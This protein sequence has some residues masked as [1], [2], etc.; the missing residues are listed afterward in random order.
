MGREIVVRV[1][2][3]VRLRAVD[4]WQVPASP[5]LRLVLGLM[6]L[7]IGQVVP[8]AELIDAIWEDEP[9]RSARASL[10]ALMTRLRQL[11]KPLPGASFTRCGDGYLF[12]FDQ[13]LV[14]AERSRSLGRAARAADGAGAIPLFDAALALWNG[15][16]LA[17]APD[18]ERVTAIRH[19]LAEERLS[20][21]QDRLAC[22]LA[23]GGEREAAAELPVALARHP[24]NERLAGMLMATWYRSGQRAEALAVFRQIRARLDV[25][26]N[27]KTP[28]YRRGRIL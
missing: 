26:W 8:V 7:R 6:A 21:L 20:M 28:L 22:M 23:C 15:P 13:D 4:R 2:G 24:L 3:P 9:P 11:L 27:G 18:T 1:L 5:Q 17:D 14:D 12:E 19:G 25:I 10:Q 16:A